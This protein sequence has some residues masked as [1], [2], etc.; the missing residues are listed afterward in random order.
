MGKMLVLCALPLPLLFAPLEAEPL[1]VLLITGDDHGVEVESYGDAQAHTPHLNQLGE[2][3]VLFERG[4]VTQASCSPSRSSILTGLYP[5]QNG[6]L[7]LAHV[8]H[9][10]DPALPNLANLPPASIALYFQKQACPIIRFI[11]IN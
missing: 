1:N 3:G 11:L 9:S 2:M 8:G 7:G 5:H 10:I 4:Y 6:Q